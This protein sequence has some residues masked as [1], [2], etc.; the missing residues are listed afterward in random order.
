MTFAAAAI[1]L[2]FIYFLLGGLIF[3]FVPALLKKKWGKGFIFYGVIIALLLQIVLAVD[4][5]VFSLYRF[6]VNLAMLDLFVNGGGQIISF[7]TATILSIVLEVVVLLFFSAA[8][9]IL[10]FS[11]AKKREGTYPSLTSIRRFP[12]RACCPQP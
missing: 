2:F 8:A 12:V 10:A 3:L 4:A 1:G 6:H 7:S 11:F 9:V 5:H